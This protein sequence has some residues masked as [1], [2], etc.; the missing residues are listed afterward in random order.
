MSNRELYVN[1]MGPINEAR[2]SSFARY[3]SCCVSVQ[4]RLC[5]RFAEGHREDEI[6]HHMWRVGML[7]AL[8]AQIIGQPPR[9]IAMLRIGACLHDIGK[10]AIPNHILE[11]PG[12]LNSAEF[13]RMK[14]HTLL[15]GLILDGCDPLL[16][17]ASQIAVS[18][19]ERWDG[20]GY[21]QGL[22]GDT[23]PLPA[24]IAA[25]ADVFDALTHARPYKKAWNLR[26]AVELI[27][28]ESGRQF[29]PNLVAAFL[30]IF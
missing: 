29:D 1:D 26:K 4:P 27:E 11:K 28:Q 8:L 24:R 20:S 30:S 10:I 14:S 6:S 7:S 15:G 23:I 5:L 22:A 21:P 25:I 16:Q 12:T 18:H 9:E 19:H 13:N 2:R 3:T 17:V